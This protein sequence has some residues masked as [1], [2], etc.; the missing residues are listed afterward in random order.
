MDTS[1]GFR[2][3]DTVWSC[4]LVGEMGGIVAGVYILWDS[5]PGESSLGAGFVWPLTVR[6][7]KSTSV[8]KAHLGDRSVVTTRMTF[9]FLVGFC[10]V[11]VSNPLPS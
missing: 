2:K 1:G 6:Q 4:I 11:V 7:L 9:C 3:R 5:Q 10:L 8:T